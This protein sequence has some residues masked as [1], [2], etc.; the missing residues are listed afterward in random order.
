M[1]WTRHMPSERMSTVSNPLDLFNRFMNANPLTHLAADFPAF[2]L[3]A[4]DEGVVLTSELPGVKLEDLDISVSGKNVTI[5]GSRKPEEVAEKS[6]RIRHERPE[7]EFERAFQLPYSI[8]SGKVEATLKN[9]VLCITLPR[10]ESE[11]PR[12]ITVTVHG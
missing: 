4:D 11:K 5:K 2:N 12:K 3:W 10:A 8:E 9:G 1:S 7:G 6:S